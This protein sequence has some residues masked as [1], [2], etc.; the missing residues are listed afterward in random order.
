M[1]P[2]AAACRDL[3]RLHKWLRLAWAGQPPAYEGELNPG[4]F[5]VVQL[6]HNRDA[7]TYEEP[8]TFREF[9]DVTPRIGDNGQ[10][11]LKRAYRGPVFNRNGGTARDWDPLFRKA[12]FVHSFDN[13]GD[14]FSGRFLVDVKH[15]LVPMARRVIASAV[16][17]GRRVKSQMNDVSGAAADFLWHE[18]NKSSA[19]TV[20]SPWKHNRHDPAVKRL[21]GDRPKAD[22]ADA[23]MPPA[24]PK[25]VPQ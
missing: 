9:W 3:Y 8:V 10:V 13:P 2:P 23:F 16:E 12:V 20:I 17:K 19:S 5:T 24:P 18:A 15:A 4:N 11:M 7:G 21:A 22:L 1:L 14:I 25:D 6:Y